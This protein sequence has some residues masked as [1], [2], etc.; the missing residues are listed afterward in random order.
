MKMVLCLCF[1]GE[2]GLLLS[3]GLVDSFPLEMQEVK[4]QKKGEGKRLPPS[5]LIYRQVPH[6]SV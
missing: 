6:F 4:H 3:F 5:Y 1:E 2:M